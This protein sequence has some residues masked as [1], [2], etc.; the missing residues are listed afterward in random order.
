MFF[1]P[2]GCLLRTHKKERP[3]SCNRNRS[4]VTEHFN[5]P[6]RL[7]NLYLEIP[8]HLAVIGFYMNSSLHGGSSRGA[9]PTWT[10]RET[11][12]RIGKKQREREKWIPW[13]NW[14]WEVMRRPN[15]DGESGVS[16]ITV[17]TFSASFHH[18][19]HHLA[20]LLLSSPLFIPHWSL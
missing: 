1:A 7:L 15:K 3:T 20:P 16:L 8:I 10:G 11:S 18:H 14:E 4:E 17:M 12:P 5:L 13:R 19:Y 2:L 6:R 9:T